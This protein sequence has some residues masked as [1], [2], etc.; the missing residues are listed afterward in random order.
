VSQIVSVLVNKETEDVNNVCRVRGV[1]VSK[2]DK[3]TFNN[4]LHACDHEVPAHL[5]KL[6]NRATV[7]RSPEETKVVANHL[8]KFQATFSKDKWDHGLANLV[9]HSINTGDAPLIKQRPRRVPLAYAD[10]EKAAF[11]DLQKKGV[12]RKS[13][14]TWASPIVLVRKKTGGVCPCI[15]YR[16]LNQLVKPDGFPPSR[17]QDCLGAVVGAALFSSFDMTCGYYQIPVK[18]D[19]PK[20]AFCSK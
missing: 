18:E 15:D 5:K 13:T 3:D 11:E 17:I 9:E 4:L 1:C 6:F 14:S 2:P 16:K 8:T 20:T 12:I 19:I 10:A 7:G